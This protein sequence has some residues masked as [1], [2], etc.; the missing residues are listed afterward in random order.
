[1]QTVWEQLPE[2]NLGTRDPNPGGL[3]GG[4]GIELETVF[5]KQEVPGLRLKRQCAWL[6]IWYKN[7][8]TN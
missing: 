4:S 6:S 5:P 1:M 3:G 7:N 2:K 8:N